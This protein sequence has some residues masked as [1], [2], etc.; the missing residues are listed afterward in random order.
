MNK[1]EFISALAEK[2]NVPK[3]KAE[4]MVN[5]SCCIIEATIA[6]GETV[7]LLGFGSFAPVD[8]APRVATS[9]SGKRIEIPA[10]KAVVFSASKSFKDLLNPP[11]RKRGRP[12]KGN[13]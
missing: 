12:R 7:K 1:G 13:A 9:F 4:E 6:A 2:C 5:A 8:R 10:K 3:V 11:K